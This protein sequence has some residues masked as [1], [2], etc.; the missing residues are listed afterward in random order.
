MG[1]TLKMG[2]LSGKVRATRRPTANFLCLQLVIN[3]VQIAPCM[4]VMLKVTYALMKRLDRPTCQSHAL[5]EL[6]VNFC[7]RL[8]LA[9]GLSSS[10]S[11]S[12]A[13]SS[14]ESSWLF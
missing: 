11:L 6:W 12:L 1:V 9:F 7:Q 2:K 10:F 8:V 3:M 14:L 4:V 13:W 5:L